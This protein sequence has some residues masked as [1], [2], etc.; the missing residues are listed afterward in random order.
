MNYATNHDDLSILQRVVLILASQ[1]ELGTRFIPWF[2]REVCESTAWGPVEVI[3]HARGQS[4]K[5]KL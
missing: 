5:M 2:A 4:L 1:S 3:I